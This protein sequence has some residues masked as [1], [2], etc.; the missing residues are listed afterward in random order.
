MKLIKLI[1]LLFIYSITTTT[2]FSQELD[3]IFDMRNDCI[4]GQAEPI[5]IP[6][7]ENKAHFEL[8][9]D[10]LTGVERFYTTQGDF[11]E[12]TNSGCEYY[13]LTFRIETSKYNAETSAL[14]YW[15]LSTYKLMKDIS[16]QLDSPIEINE[17]LDA[18]NNYISKNVFELKLEEEIDFGEDVIR[19]FVTLKKIEKIH[20][21]KYAVIISFSVGP[22]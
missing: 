14:K 4:R 6:T 12:I 5:V 1:F 20:Q 3:T 7:I 9:K 22:L 16:T 10:S 8:Q 17:G 18:L 13:T 15:Y 2:C 19:S 21:N 11:V